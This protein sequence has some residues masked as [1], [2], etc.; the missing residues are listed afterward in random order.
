M[1]LLSPVELDD[2]IGRLGT[3]IDVL[4]GNSAE[5]VEAWLQD[6][7]SGL[8]ECGVPEKQF[9]EVIW[10]RLLSPDMQL[11]LRTCERAFIGLI[12]WS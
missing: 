5:N 7:V 1:K 6:A 11:A 3:S 8:R 10:P 2:V 12:I 9:N 4:R